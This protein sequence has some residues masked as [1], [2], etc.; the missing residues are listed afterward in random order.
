M[1]YETSRRMF[2]QGMVGGAA[3]WPAFEGLPPVAGESDWERVAGSSPLR[4]KR[5]P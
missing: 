5:S 2:L 1:V 3:A 4:R